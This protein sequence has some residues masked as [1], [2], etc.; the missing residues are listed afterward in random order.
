ALLAG[1]RAYREA[2][3]RPRRRERTIRADPLRVDV[4]LAATRVLPARERTARAVSC[5]L[6]PRLETGRRAQRDPVL[7]RREQA[8]GEDVLAVDVAFVRAPVAPHDECSARAVG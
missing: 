1:R 7:G 2:V 3:L 5:D 8:V 4:R 6:G